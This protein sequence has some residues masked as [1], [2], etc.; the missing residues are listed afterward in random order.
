MRTPSRFFLIILAAL[1]IAGCSNR[2]ASFMTP[3]P[4]SSPS[5]TSTAASTSLAGAA[6]LKVLS[7]LVTGTSVQLTMGFATSN[8]S[9]GG[10]FALGQYCSVPSSGNP[11]SRQCSC[12]FRW[13]EVNRTLNTPQLVPRAREMPVNV[14]NGNTLQCALPPVYSSEI[15]DGTSVLV[16]VTPAASNSISFFASGY[17]IV[18]GQGLIPGNITDSRGNVL[19]NIQRY[20]CFD[21]FSR[22]MAIASAESKITF[23]IGGQ[24]RALYFSM[25]NRFCAA[26]V[27]SASAGA[28]DAGQEAC[29]GAL[30]GG[31]PNSAQ[32]NYYSVYNRESES[33]AN[34]QNGNFYCP[35]VA[36]SASADYFPKDKSFALARQVSTDYPVPV[37]ANMVISGGGGSALYTAGQCLGQN[38][39]NAGGAASGIAQGCLGFAAKPNRDG[40]C[41]LL[42]DSSGNSMPTYR[43]RKY[44][45]VYPPIF[46]T[47][48]YPLA[49]TSQSVDTV[50]VL[51]RPV[52]TGN[53]QVLNGSML[54]PKPCPF[55]YYDKGDATRGPSYKATNN[56]FWTGKNVDG[57]KLP[58]T[59]NGQPQYIGGYAASCP[60][61][62]PHWSF[63]AGAYTGVTLSSLGANENYYI[64]P[65]VAWTPHYEED[66]AFQ[67]CTPRSSNIVDPPIHYAINGA[68]CAEI[69]PNAN[70]TANVNRDT[71][72]AQHTTRRPASAPSTASSSFPLLAPEADI[73]A[74]LV[75][76]PAYGCTVT[77]DGKTDITSR[78]GTKP[79]A[80]ACCVGANGATRHFE[81]GA[82]VGTPSL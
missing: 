13:N 4:K 80:S 44:Y 76:D 42:T 17:N 61:V 79:A 67:A 18:K 69:Y 58:S 22:G 27:A 5:S 51:D 23:N 30:L 21:Q 62:V 52:N 16:E 6:Q 8:T 35:T 66:L 50:F 11:V 28:S 34:I 9:T 78:R 31:A 41:P 70:G 81:S 29:Q 39:Q 63:A 47:D 48:G 54:G 59:S 12:T 57:I 33:A 68:Y 37:E 65:M 72:G 82:C 71:L 43:L 24:D 75:S 73:E 77:W 60:A 56:A 32:S 36:Q 64:R 38:N 74:A 53:A 19:S 25:A 14:T 49:N 20:V 7:A 46:D 15:P 45:V 1:S 55:A 10:T 26:R 2:G 3:K 40:S